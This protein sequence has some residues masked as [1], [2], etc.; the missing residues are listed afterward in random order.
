MPDRV[1]EPRRLD[2]RTDPELRPRPVLP[3]QPAEP[4]PSAFGPYL[5]MSRSLQAMWFVI[6]WS[7]YL[8]VTGMGLAVVLV[9]ILALL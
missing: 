8:V 9:L 3:Y 7:V 6:V 5:P 4:L 2:Y 1:P